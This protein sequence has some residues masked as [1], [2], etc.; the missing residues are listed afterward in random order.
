MKRLLSKKEK[1]IWWAH[2]CRFPT[3]HGDCVREITHVVEDAAGHERYLCRDH[4]DLIGREVQGQAR[5]LRR[6]E[7]E[8]VKS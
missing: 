5:W 1:A 8:E 3:I 4:A 7:V 2:R 6:P